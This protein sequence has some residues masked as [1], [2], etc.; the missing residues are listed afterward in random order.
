MGDQQATVNQKYPFFIDWNS[1]AMER[2]CFYYAD[3]RGKAPKNALWIGAKNLQ[4]VGC[5]TEYLTGSLH[6]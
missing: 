4:D 2:G 1:P 3:R 6:M 5:L